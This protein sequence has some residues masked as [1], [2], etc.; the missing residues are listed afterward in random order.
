[1][2]MRNGTEQHTMESIVC[3]GK[4][5]SQT[6]AFRAVIGHTRSTN[7]RYN[8]NKVNYDIYWIHDGKKAKNNK[9]TDW[10]IRRMWHVFPLYFPRSFHARVADNTKRSPFMYRNGIITRCY[11]WISNKYIYCLT[12]WPCVCVCA[13]AAMH[14][15]HSLACVCVCM[16]WSSGC[17]S[18][19]IVECASVVC[20]FNELIGFSGVA[21]RK[22]ARL[23][24]WPE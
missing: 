13:C 18:L 12:G 2:N 19:R 1:M 11:N 15:A 5:Y 3:R 23:I 20:H 8:W 22:T 6:T 7:I 16:K 14:N 10:V 17:F 9:Y 21:E 4:I 24:V